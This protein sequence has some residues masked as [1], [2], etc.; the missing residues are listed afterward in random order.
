[1]PTSSREALR[2]DILHIKHVKKFLEFSK[3][4][5]MLAFIVCSHFGG[6]LFLK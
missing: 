6:S 2:N 3:C 4:S 1:M 5:V